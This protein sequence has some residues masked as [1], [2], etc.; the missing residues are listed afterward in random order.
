MPTLTE[1]PTLVNKHAYFASA[2]SPNL[3]ETPGEGFLIA[4]G[5]RVARTGVQFYRPDE[6]GAEG[7]DLIKVIRTP[8]EVFAPDTLRSGEGKSLTETHPA[9]FTDSFTDLGY[10]RG[11]AQNFRRSGQIEADGTE[12]LLADLIVKDAGLIS[13]IKSGVMRQISV[14]YSCSYEPNGDGTYNQTGIRI[15]HIAV[16]VA[17]RAGDKVRIVDHAHALE[18]AADNLAQVAAVVKIEAAEIA[19]TQTVLEETPM[20]ATPAVEKQQAAQAPVEAVKDSIRSMPEFKKEKRMDTTNKKAGFVGRVMKALALT[21]ADPTEFEEAFQQLH[22]TNAD[23]TNQLNTNRRFVRTNDADSDPDDD[24][25]AKDKKAKDAE[26]KLTAAEK[27]ASDAEAEV[28]KF[29]KKE[30]EDAKAAADAKVKDSEETEA[31]KEDGMELHPVLKQACD[32]IMSMKDDLSAIK[33]HLGVEDD[34][35]SETSDQ[36]LIPVVTKPDDRPENPISGADK[37]TS[38]SISL[39]QRRANLLAMKPIITQSNDAAAKAAW[40]NDWKTV[41]KVKTSDSK[42][43]GHHALLHA[44]RPNGVPAGSV[45]QANDSATPQIDAAAVTDFENKINATRARLQGKVN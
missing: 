37:P 20:A 40:N 14:G 10:S 36:D 30:S 3:L 21:D 15:N 4:P 44:A 38:D 1:Q 16:V 45:M 24:K 9:Q 27:R 2:I 34:P 39:E 29:K 41:S 12:Y 7:T 22:L 25:K 33:S 28:E 31:R 23:A 32:H 26:E 42:R 8:A 6:I 18:E 19:A 5:T 11:H 17:G 13:K 35:D 43:N